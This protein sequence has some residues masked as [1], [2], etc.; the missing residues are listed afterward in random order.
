M[1]AHEWVA[2]KTQFAGRIEQTVFTFV[3]AVEF[4]DVLFQIKV[5]IFRRAFLIKEEPR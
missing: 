5:R 1:Q 3:Q 2:A 4:L